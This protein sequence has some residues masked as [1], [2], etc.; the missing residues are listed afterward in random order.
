M[1]HHQLI[2]G[3]RG[4]CIKLSVKSKEKEII[5][6]LME[7]KNI[8]QCEGFN[9]DRDFTIIKS[10]KK[11]GKEQYSTPYTLLNLDYDASDVVERLKELTIREYS[12]TLVDKDDISVC[13]MENQK[14]ETLWRQL[15]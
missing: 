7:L 11:N 1:I 12:E 15:H 5:E 2:E 4:D 8:L 10:K 14:E 6:F 13:I 3:Y 9:I